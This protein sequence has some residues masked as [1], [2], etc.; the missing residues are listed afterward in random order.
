[1]TSEPLLLKPKVA[2]YEEIKAFVGQKCTSYE[3]VNA[4]VGQ[5]CHTLAVIIFIME[6][7]LGWTFANLWVSGVWP[8]SIVVLFVSGAMACCCAHL[9]MFE[10]VSEHERRMKMLHT[11]EKLL[12]MC[13]VMIIAGPM[14]YYLFKGQARH[15]ALLFVCACVFTMCSGAL[16]GLREGLDLAYQKGIQS[17]TNPQ[18]QGEVAEA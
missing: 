12:L 1:M 10:R 11:T 5:K 8:L 15:V 7:A 14:V 16:S 2:S 13:T 9:I 4:V 6:L 3:E 17:V 18:K